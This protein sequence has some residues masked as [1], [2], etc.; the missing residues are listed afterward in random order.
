MLRQGPSAGLHIVLSLPT[1][2]SVKQIFERGQLELFK[3]RIATQMGDAD[4]FLIF[5]RDAAS[6][7]QRES[8]PIFALHRDTSSGKD[9]KF[10]PCTVDAEIPWDEQFQR[11]ASH[12]AAWR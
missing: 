5:E 1:A 10:K 4:S 7:L 8:S 9:T 6:R 11:L 3:H 12:F 2:A